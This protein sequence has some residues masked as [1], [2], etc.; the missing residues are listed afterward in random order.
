MDAG[1]PLIPVTKHFDWKKRYDKAN[2][3]NGVIQRD[4]W[5]DE[6]ERKAILEFHAKHPLQGY[7]RLTLMTLDATVV[8]A[9]PSSV[10]RVLSQTGVLSPFQGKR[11][12]KLTGQEKELFAQRY[13]KLEAARER[14][15]LRRP[16]A[17]QNAA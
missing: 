9:S 5:L 8:A 6:S 15:R 10:H 13:Q 1:F 4:H 2:E 12:K 17:I 11:S 14:R 7:R 3:H 16:E